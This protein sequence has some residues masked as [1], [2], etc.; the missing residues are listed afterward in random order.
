ME[1]WKNIA[2]E[3]IV[4][5]GVCGEYSELL[6]RAGTASAALA[7]YKRGIDWCLE[8]NSPSIN[9]LRQYKQECEQNSVFID[10]TFHGEILT[11][12]QVYVFHNC[13]GTIRV[14]L[15]MEKHIIPMLYF[16]NGCAM[17]V[18]SADSSGLSIRVPL[19]V[20]G[21]NSINAE[22]S[23]DIVCVFINKDAK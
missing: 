14:G 12:E 13:R 4:S 18:K 3:D 19:Y 9:L 7:L 20:F 22:V 2:H 10:R 21:P 8:R 1:K 6:N 11:G 17:S 15:N 5:H 23:E 16:A